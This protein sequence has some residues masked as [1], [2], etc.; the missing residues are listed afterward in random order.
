MSQTKSYWLSL[1]LAV[2]CDWL[3]LP[4]DTGMSFSGK[5]CICTSL[6]YTYQAIKLCHG[7]FGPWLPHVPHL[8]TALPTRVDMLGRVADG[9]CTDHLAMGQCV[10]LACM[11]WDASAYEG[12]RWEGDW[13]H[14]PISA[15]MEGIG[16]RRT[17]GKKQGG[18]VKWREEPRQNHQQGLDDAKPQLGLRTSCKIQVSQPE[19]YLEIDEAK[20]RTLWAYS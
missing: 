12:I 16:P 2:S 15:H 10:E 8:H 11:P 7:G 20:Q 18:G 14:L 5:L 19:K 6:P 9:D 13:L 4:T 1:P 17:Q 3:C